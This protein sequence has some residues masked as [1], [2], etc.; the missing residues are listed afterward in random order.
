MIKQMDSYKKTP[1]YVLLRTR[2]MKTMDIK[3]ISHTNNEGD[4]RII[5]ETGDQKTRYSKIAMTARDNE[6][7][8]YRGLAIADIKKYE[9]PYLLVQAKIPNQ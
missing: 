7:E 8:N 9:H 4:G 3:T 6:G 5:L 2:H 1:E